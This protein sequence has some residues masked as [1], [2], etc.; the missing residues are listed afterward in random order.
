MFDKK[1]YHKNYYLANTEKI[2]ACN[3]NYY[4]THQEEKKAYHSAYS[5]GYN[6]KHKKKI[7]ACQKAWYLANKEKASISWKKHQQTP[8]GKQTKVKARAKR[9]QLGFIPLNEWFEGADAHHINKERVV[10]I[11]KELHQSIWHSL[12]QNINMKAINTK[13]KQ[14]LQTQ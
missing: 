2:K 3:K 12:L 4:L 14:F 1:A 6:L 13:A 9:K 8:K 10:Y 11:P 5:K 7:R